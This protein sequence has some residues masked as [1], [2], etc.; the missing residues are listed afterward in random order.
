MQQPDFFPKT[1][2][3]TNIKK[4]NDRK[5]VTDK[6][7]DGTFGEDLVAA[8]LKSKGFFILAATRQ[9]NEID[10]VVQNVKNKIYK[11][12]VKAKSS[13][14]SYR[15]YVGTGKKDHKYI[16]IKDKKT[17]SIEFNV[18]RNTAGGYSGYQHIDVYC[19]VWLPARR[20]IFFINETNKP[21]SRT[22][23]VDD[24][25]A[26]KENLSYEN[27]FEKNTSIKSAETQYWKISINDNWQN[28]KGET[29]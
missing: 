18:R 3:K 12:Q 5:E 10:L 7:I 22:M 13:Q 15:K 28:I 20:I 6:V 9:N 23:R 21:F 29:E 26:E 25:D 19:L 1:Q 2:S 27:C 17:K 24:F 4:E 14:R 8:Y 11:L 16:T